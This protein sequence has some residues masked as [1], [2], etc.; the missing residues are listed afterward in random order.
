MPSC[1]WSWNTAQITKKLTCNP[2]H[3]TGPLKTDPL[4]W[5]HTQVLHSG[6]HV[7]LKLAMVNETSLNSY[8]STRGNH[9]S[10]KKDE[11]FIS[12][13]AIR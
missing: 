3:T 5:T 9:P 1:S 8:S 13:A 11:S 7:L 2:Q 10:L 6:S 12:K 4:F